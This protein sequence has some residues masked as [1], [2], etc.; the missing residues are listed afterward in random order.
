MNFNFTQEFCSFV[1]YFQM[2]REIFLE[3]VK[4][5]LKQHLNF[6]G[7][8]FARETE[9]EWGKISA[10]RERLK[11]GPELRV[12]AWRSVGNGIAWGTWGGVLT[13]WHRTGCSRCHCQPQASAGGV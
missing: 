2:K 6:K 8:L 12:S 7:K 13:P 1:N 10:S 4:K 11:G 3:R 9:D 5:G